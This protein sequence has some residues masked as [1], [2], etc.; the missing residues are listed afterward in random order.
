[1]AF[2]AKDDPTCSAI[3]S[4]RPRRT[5]L[6]HVTVSIRLHY[7]GWN[8]GH[9]ADWF[10]TMRTLMIEAAIPT[11]LVHLALL[12]RACAASWIIS[13][14]FVENCLPDFCIRHARRSKRICG[15]RREQCGDSKRSDLAYIA[16][17]FPGHAPL[18]YF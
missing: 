12:I 8:I 16:N 5:L 13:K 2:A 10:V 3:S 18:P 15:H 11:D 14:R 17:D 4:N 7:P 9:V 1:M 6:A